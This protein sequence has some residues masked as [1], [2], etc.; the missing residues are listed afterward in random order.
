MLTQYKHVTIVNYDGPPTSDEIAA[1]ETELGAGLPP[2]FRDFLDVA[3]GGYLPY[4]VNVPPAPDGEPMS[5]NRIFSTRPNAN[6]ELSYG[7]FIGELR[8]KPKM[9]GIPDKVLPFA[10]DGGGSSIYLDLTVEGKGRVVAFIH[11]LPSWTGLREQ[12]AFVEVADTF[13]HFV[14]QLYVDPDDDWT[15]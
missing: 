14:G 6:G 8:N 9:L 3:N 1:L 4:L 7:T 10:D 13:S 11:G 2:K 5:F 15:E 12:D